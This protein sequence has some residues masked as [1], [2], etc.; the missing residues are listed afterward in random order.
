MDVKT[1]TMYQKKRMSNNVESREKKAKITMIDMET[2]NK[3]T[4]KN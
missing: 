3:K 4:I 2:R 1:H